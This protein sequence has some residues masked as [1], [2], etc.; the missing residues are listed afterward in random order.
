MTWAQVAGWLF[1][2]PHGD[3]DEAA[4]GREFGGGLA[5]AGVARGPIAPP[6]DLAGVGTPVGCGVPPVWALPAWALPV[7]A[8][9][10]WALPAWT[11]P[12]WTLPAW[13]LPAWTLPAWTLPAWTL[14]AWT[15]PAWT[16]PAW[17]LP[18]ARR[19]ARAV[20]T[21]VRW[22]SETAPIAL[23]RAAGRRP[24]Q[25]RKLSTTATTRTP[26]TSSDST[27]WGVAR[28]SGE[29]DFIPV[30][31][32]ANRL[33]PPFSPTVSRTPGSVDRR[34][35]GRDHPAQAKVTTTAASFRS[36]VVPRYPKNVW[37]RCSIASKAPSSPS[38]SGTVEAS[39]ASQAMARRR[40]PIGR[41][42]A[43]NDRTA[44]AKPLAASSPTAT[45]G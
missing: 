36:P 1:V 30:G 27:A 32:P 19:E 45:S 41:G 28:L 26:I 11:L 3:E 16:L 34:H 7:W 6:V 33:P 10:V 15:L 29:R 12:A 39:T 38:A 4:G 43:A 17:T 9:P 20:V 2:L 5:G 35:R 37:P 23:P 18:V 21:D 40:E 8:L 22:T 31:V 44:A 24:D 25:P 13:T 42:R 14:P